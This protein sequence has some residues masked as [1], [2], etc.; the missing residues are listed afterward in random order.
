LTFI[1]ANFPESITE[2]VFS[3]KRYVMCVSHSLTFPVLN[4]KLHNKLSILLIETEEKLDIG[5]LGSQSFIKYR[6]FVFSGD[7]R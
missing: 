3:V 2:I 4:N 6:S 5:V 7:H 1:L